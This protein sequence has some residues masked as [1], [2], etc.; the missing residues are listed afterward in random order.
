MSRIEA[1]LAVLAFCAGCSKP[2]EESEAKQWPKPLPTGK[3]VQIRS[4]LSI[5]VTVDGAAKP[6]I[7]G[8]LL[9]STKPD[10]VDADRKAWRIPTLIGPVVGVVEASGADGISVKFPQATA[11]LEPVLFL[12]R[13]GDIMASAVDPKDPFPGHHGQGGRLHRPGDSLP[14]VMQVAKLEIK[15]STP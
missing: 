13:R 10:F 8:D 4:D 2:A 9:R 14:R 5:A 6:A 15:R 3:D 12:T 1:L 7:T 11:D